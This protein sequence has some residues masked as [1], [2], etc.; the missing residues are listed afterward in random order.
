MELQHIEES[1]HMGSEISSHKDINK[2]DISELITMIYRERTSEYSKKANQLT[3]AGEATNGTPK[4]I[5]FFPSSFAACLDIGKLCYFSLS[6]TNELVFV[7]L[8]IKVE[9]IFKYTGKIHTRI[10]SCNFLTSTDSSVEISKEAIDAMAS[11]PMYSSKSSLPNSIAK[12]AAGSIIE[13]L[14]R[15]NDEKNAIRVA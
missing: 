15:N 12:I 1:P 10:F 8:D 6:L 2:K 11:W 5:T 14:K 4:Y 7:S 3:N 13:S 9:S